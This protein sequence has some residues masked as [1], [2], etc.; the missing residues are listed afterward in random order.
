LELENFSKQ[1]L[2][3]LIEFNGRLFYFVN[4]WERGPGTNFFSAVHSGPAKIAM[5]ALAQL[6]I[7]VAK[8]NA[9]ADTHDSTGGTDGSEFVSQSRRKVVSIV[10]FKLDTYVLASV[11]NVGSPAIT[12]RNVVEPTCDI[13]LVP[14]PMRYVE[15]GA[16]CLH[17]N[18]TIGDRARQICPIPRSFWAF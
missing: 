9:E 4:E 10:T 17:Q 12:H 13:T 11:V 16:L 5:D 7:G 6:L 1:T 8:A 2:R 14:R 15:A 18:Y 3:E